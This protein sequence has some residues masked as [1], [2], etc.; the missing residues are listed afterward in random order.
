MQTAAV[1]SKVY[2]NNVW[3]DSKGKVSNSL[4]AKTPPEV[5][6]KGNIATNRWP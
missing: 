3:T 4:R 2:R 6:K 5:N 1:V